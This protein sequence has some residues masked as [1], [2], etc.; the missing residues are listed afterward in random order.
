MAL[1]APVSCGGPHAAGIDPCCLD[2]SVD[3][4]FDPPPH[5]EGLQD[6]EVIVNQRFDSKGVVATLADPAW[7]TVYYF[8]NDGGISWQ[9]DQFYQE[10]RAR[11]IHALREGDILPWNPNPADPKVQYR[12][13]YKKMLKSY[14]ERS[15]DGGKTWVRMKGAITD[16]NVEMDKG[17]SYFY[18]PRD[19]LTLYQS[20]SLP[21]WNYE[22]GVFV[23]TDGGDNNKFMYYSSRIAPALAISQSN[24]N[25]MFGAGPMGSLLKSGDGG[26]TWDFVSQNDQIRKTYI[27]KYPAGQKLEEKSFDKS[28]TNIWEI[29]IDPENEQRVYV[30]SSKG[31]LR[32]ENGGDTW[33][34]LN[35]GISKADGINTVAIAPGK[36]EVILIGT[37][38]GLLRSSDHGCHWGKIDVLGRALQ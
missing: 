34:I 36:P 20:S 38:G 27:R 25:V 11:Q 12:T 7:E 5:I 6:G 1:L 10:L 32:S 31:L 30:A 16:S 22:K 24:P 33:C 35:T 14:H 4:I 29:A 8:S 28:N 17:G 23:S 18:H 9:H 2:M 3:R 26:A 37:Y 21:G 19:A 13:I 15:T